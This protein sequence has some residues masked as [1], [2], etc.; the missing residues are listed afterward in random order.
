MTQQPTPNQRQLITEATISSIH[1]P[2]PMREGEYPV[3]FIVGH[4]VS[5]ITYRDDYHGDHSIGW[6]D[7]WADDET[8]IASLSERHIA[9]VC[10]HIP[11]KGQ[12]H[13]PS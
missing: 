8:L 10:Y 6:F 3:C 4:S 13:D 2:E 1:G 5:Q 7:V 12:K 11:S 9:Q